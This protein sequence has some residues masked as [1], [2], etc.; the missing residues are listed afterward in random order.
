MNRGLRIAE[1]V[2][3]DPVDPVLQWRLVVP[4]ARGPGEH[5]TVEDGAPDIR[6][7][8]LVRVP[9]RL[10]KRGN[11]QQHDDAGSSSEP[12]PGRPYVCGV[13]CHSVC[14]PA[15]ASSAILHANP[16]CSTSAMTSSA[17]MMTSG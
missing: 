10:E 5:A 17:A 8:A 12:R 1:E 14:H 4:C 6:V 15:P 3:H 2:G 7:G 16:S 9:V 13:A 11:A